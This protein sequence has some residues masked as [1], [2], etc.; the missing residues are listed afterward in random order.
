MALNPA[1]GMA[2]E[3][4]VISTKLKLPFSVVVPIMLARMRQKDGLLLWLTG[5]SLV[6]FVLGLLFVV[7]PQSVHSYD[8]TLNEAKCA[9]RGGEYERAERLFRERLAKNARD[10]EAQLGLSYTLLKRRKFLG[11]YESARQVLS[12]DR[13]SARA[14]ALIG[15]ALLATGDFQQSV[16]AFQSSLSLKDNEPLATAGLAMIEFY[17]NRLSTS[18]KG[19]RRAVAFDPKEPDFLFSLAQAATRAERFDEAADSYERFLEVAPLTEEDRRARIRGLVE[20]LHYL[21]GI[22]KLYLVSGAERIT[23]PFVLV[24]GRP[25]IQVTVNDSGEPLRFVLDTGSAMCVISKNTADRLRLKPVARG[26]TSRAVGG[27]GRFEIVYAYLSSLRIGEIRI[28]NVPVY[29]RH[30]LENERTV[31]GYIGLAAIDKHLVTIDYGARTLTLVRQQADPG[32]QRPLSSAEAMIRRTSSGFISGE[33]QVEG[34]NG[35]SNFILDTGASVSVV[36]ANLISQENMD[37]FAVGP[38]ARIYGAAGIAEDVKALRL[39]RVTFGNQRLE[40]LYAV[41]LDLES[42]NETTGFSQSGI[43][44]G[45]FLS[46]FRVTID[47]RRGAIYL[48]P[49]TGPPRADQFHGARLTPLESTE[50]QYAA[51]LGPIRTSTRGR[52]SESKARATR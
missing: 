48:E 37:R 20:L 19:L 43:L 30:F 18:L 8:K 15:S 33:V 21:A 42:I 6:I 11:A 27:I 52:H 38:R 34:V 1:V 28:E 3:F 7:G 40:A 12:E 51:P 2:L 29:L 22:K 23:I 39:P 5:R 47:F 45:N 14:Y 9:L 16:A 26:G 25:I 50:E 31:D 17:E 10:V 35:V 24:N 41:V 49:L 4:S 36:S 46:N 32:K 44:G 13:H